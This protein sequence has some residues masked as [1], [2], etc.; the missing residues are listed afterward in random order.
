MTRG[1]LRK[2]QCFL[3]MNSTFRPHLDF[4]QSVPPVSTMIVLAFALTAFALLL[5]PDDLED[6]F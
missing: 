1:I 3:V 4:L 2:I 5:L 6:A